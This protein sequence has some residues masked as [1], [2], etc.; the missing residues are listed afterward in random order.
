MCDV[1]R[2]LRAKQSE[3]FKNDDY[4]PVVE[5]VS[6]VVEDATGSSVVVKFGG[7]VEDNVGL[8]VEEEYPMLLEDTVD[9]A[10]IVGF[11]SCV[12]GCMSSTLRNVL[13]CNSV[14]YGGGH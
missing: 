10:E 5:C 4:V 3:I 12:L 2:N 6:S 13:Y 14:K 7:V 9:E 8:I 1:A 11:G